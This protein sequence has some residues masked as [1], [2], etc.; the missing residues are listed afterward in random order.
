MNMKSNSHI[1]H[2]TTETIS[3]QSRDRQLK[4]LIKEELPHAPSD[5]WFANKVMNRL[6]EKRHGFHAS[7]PEK[8]CYGM[9]AVFLIAAWVYSITFTNANGI[10][11]ISITM[12][13]VLPVLTLFC[14]GIFAIPAIKRAL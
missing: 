5:E 4:S 9:G 3:E 6:P 13:V 10:T 2:P 14:I 12:A 8:I 1:Y 11:P 7:L